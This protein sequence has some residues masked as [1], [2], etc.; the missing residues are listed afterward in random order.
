MQGL[1]GKVVVIAGA[2]RGIGAATASRFAEEG[3]RVVV[4]DLNEAGAVATAAAITASGGTAIGVGFDLADES[5][6]NAP[7][8]TAADHFGGIDG[9]H[10]N[11]ASV[12]ADTMGFDLEADAL[13]RSL[14]AWD[15]TYAVNA[16]GFLLGIRAAVPHLLARGGGAIVNTLSDGAF[17]AVPNLS[18]SNSSKSAALELTRHV[19]ARW[20]KDG[21]RCNAVSPGFVLTD[22]LLAN[23]PAQVVEG[24]LQRTSSPRLG[25]PGD[26]AAAVAFLMSDDGA[27]VN[28]HVLHVNG[29]A[30]MRGRLGREQRQKRYACRS[31]ERTIVSVGRDI[32]H[33]H[34]PSRALVEP[35]RSKRPNTRG[36]EN[37]I[38]ASES[39]VL[40]DVGCELMFDV[41]EASLLALQVAPAST[42][43]AIVEERLEITI[44]GVPVLTPA[45]GIAADHGG[46]I[47]L[48]SAPAGTLS[49]TYVAA[50]RASPASPSAGDGRDSFTSLDDVVALRQRRYCP[51][52]ALAGFAATEFPGSVR[53][54]PD[55]VAQRV[56][57]WVFER[58]AYSVESS[59][60]LDTAV[61]TLLSGS[62]VCR[63]FA[64]LTIAL[65]RALGV[66]ARLA[67]VYAPGL[68]PM[69]F[70]AVVEIVTPAGWQV[71]D[72]TRLAPR[73]ALVRMA[74][75]RDAAETA[76]AT[77]RRGPVEL[78]ASRV[79]ASSDGDLPAD[80]HARPLPLA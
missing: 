76:F 68:S 19:A 67:S 12:G 30:L 72:P 4:G 23:I 10:N 66:P 73:G 79:F 62:G 80:D 5:S 49:F 55:A 22:S 15:G 74:T 57:S 9:W 51:S 65:C 70:H 24:A 61:D 56:A 28:G 59:G 39:G 58:L 38:G 18:A 25:R 47:H 50:L 63:D 29:G 34:I 48:V 26:I 54:S 60:P 75:G 11:A 46:R 16:R 77:T 43:G 2:A 78:V 52:D 8:A 6:V 21:I 13:T 20:G 71:L 41:T 69:D 42:P 27:W 33:R 40:R 32:S 1:Q 37:L 45:V 53:D 7:A 64:Q 3:A 31:R 44:D 17:S 35:R 14:D 36:T